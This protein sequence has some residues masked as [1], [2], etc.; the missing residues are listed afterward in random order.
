[1]AGATVCVIDDDPSMR[2]TVVDILALAGI[3]ARGFESGAAALAARGPGQPDLAVVDQRLPDT[4]GIA[5]ST[6]LKS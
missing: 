3:E 2:Q 4:T 1:M 6:R 5:L